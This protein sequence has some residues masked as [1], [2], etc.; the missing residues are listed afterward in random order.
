MFI[1]SGL[2]LKKMGM[3]ATYV[4]M[5]SN[6]VNIYRPEVNSME[7]WTL[8]IVQYFIEQDILETGCFCPKVES[9]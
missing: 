6:K 1:C 2:S 7:S 5:K 3:G 9:G 8:F 4:Y